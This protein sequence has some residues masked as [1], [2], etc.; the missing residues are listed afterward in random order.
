MRVRT[1]STEGVV[2]RQSDLG[3]ADRIV[4]IFTQDLGKVRL[5]AKGARRPKSRIGGHLGLL[6]QVSF[7]AAHGRS[8]DVV[9]EAQTQQTFSVLS[10][11]LE[12]LSQAVYMCELLDAF[13]AER[14]PNYALYRLAIS[15][16]GWLESDNDP[17][18]L[19]RFFEAQLL[20]LSGFRPEITRCVECRTELEPG[21]HIFDIGS[22]GILCPDCRSHGIGVLLPLKLN[23]MKVLRLLQRDRD[24]SNAGT[25]RTSALVKS[26]VERVL[27]EHI[28]Y[29]LERRLKS[30]DFV[31]LVSEL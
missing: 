6:Y 12:R 18:L 30:V 27:T 7:S 3:E 8:L 1:Y 2:I 17:W 29:V 10:Q 9:S 16:L 21:D 28:R 23:A 4:T 24:F 11:D 20:D 15:S 22:G 5:V 31:R 13:T 25:I 26:E 14:S 19:V